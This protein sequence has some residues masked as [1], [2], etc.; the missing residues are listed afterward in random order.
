MR[1]AVDP[2]ERVATAF[3][4]LDARDVRPIGTGWTVD[5][6]EVDEGWIVQ[7]PRDDHAAERLRAQIQTLPEL[8]AELPALVPEPTHVDLDG[9]AIAYR[10]IEGVPL[11]EA[12]DGMWPER[13]GRVLYDLHL[14][15]PQDGGLPGGPASDGPR[16]QRA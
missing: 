12:P 6:Y 5:T 15:P 8:A 11:I 13:L 7:F 14:M 3:P 9:P 1:Q 10:K 16:G 2:H 4:E